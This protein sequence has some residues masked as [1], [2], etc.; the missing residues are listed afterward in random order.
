MENVRLTDR[1]SCTYWICCGQ[2]IC[3]SCLA[4]TYTKEVKIC[5]FCRTL[6][7]VNSKQYLDMVLQ[8]V[9][10]KKSWAQ[11]DIGLCYFV[12]IICTVFLL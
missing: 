10:K 12:G 11:Y 1:Y 9:Y 8:H 5:Y 4:H 2:L 3:Q 6:Q 7:P